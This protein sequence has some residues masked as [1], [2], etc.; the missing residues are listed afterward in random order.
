MR[1]LQLFIVIILTLKLS[2][3]STEV[4]NYANYKDI[5]IVYGLL[6]SGTDTTFIRITKAFLGPGNALLFARNP[7][8]SNY[9]GKLNVQLLGKKNNINLTP[10]VL[11]TI[12]I[13]NKKM[14]DSIFYYPQQK[15]YFTKSYID[16]A[17]IYTLNIA[18]GNT[19]VSAQTEIVQAFPITLPT[20]RIN[21]AATTATSIRWNSAVNGRRHEVKLVFYYDEMLPGSSD[22]LK[23]TMTWNMGMKKAEYL[24]GGQVLEIS[25]FGDEFY[26]RLGQ[27]IGN[28]FNVKRWASYAEIIIGS[29]ADD[30][31]TYIDVNAPNN[32]IVQEIPQFTNITNGFGIFSSRKTVVGRYKLSV[33]SEVKLVEGFNWGFQL[34]PVK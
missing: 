30:L 18:R 17:A 13:K 6:E 22:T 16:P 33:Q 2:S 9:P 19:T 7:D 12:T 21:F 25:Y 20:N 4:D 11:D 32:S 5:T 31:S 24:T 3:C 29:G 23:K 8:S 1:I 10:I 34:R 28:S 26:N 15:L 27:S 14:G